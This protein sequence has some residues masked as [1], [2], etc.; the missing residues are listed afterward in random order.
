[1][2][3]R[4]RSHILIQG[5][6]DSEAYRPPPRA[7]GSRH[8]P[9]PPDRRRHG[10]QLASE[11]QDAEAKGHDRR[12]EEQIEIPNA[13]NGVYVRFDAFEGLEDVLES[14]DPRQ[15]RV[16]P[17]LRSFRTTLVEGQLVEQAVV[18]IPD[19]KL[20]YFLKRIE[21]YL[22]TVDRVKPRNARLVDRI[23]SIGLAS[24]EQL[25]TDSGEFP[26]DDNEAWW[27]V[28]LR[29]RDG[30]EVARLRQFGHEAG[31]EIGAEALGFSDRAVILVRATA[32]QLSRALDVLDDIAELRRPREPAGLIALEQAADQAE[33]TEQLASRTNTAPSGSPAACVV[34]TGVHRAHPLLA[35]SLDTADCH[36]CEPNWGIHDKVRARHRDGRT[37]AVWRRGRC[38]CIGRADQPATSA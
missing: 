38:C 22:A 27:E 1:M 10:E 30:D 19:G 3:N 20:G 26:S 14:L 5:L 23:Q 9:P 17:E 7:I 29:R 35:P 13:I 15:G 33:W 18:F 34:D 32:N 24:L 25:W 11:L 12:S 21:Q 28:W 6:A 2:A 16:R 8:R 4:D 37:G 31:V 36:T